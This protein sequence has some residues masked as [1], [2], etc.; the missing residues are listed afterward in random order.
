MYE[1]YLDF[2]KAGYSTIQ[3]DNVQ[4]ILRSLVAPFP[5]Y[6]D[7]CRSLSDYEIG[8][9]YSIVMQEN[10]RAWESTTLFLD[11]F[12]IAWGF[13]RVMSAPNIHDRAFELYQL[14]KL[15]ESIIG[16]ILHRSKNQS[17]SLSSLDAE[18]QL[19]VLWAVRTAGIIHRLSGRRVEAI[20]LLENI[21]P[22]VEQHLYLK[23]AV[24]QIFYNKLLLE[25][26]RCYAEGGH[27]DEAGRLL[28]K[29]LKAA[30][31]SENMANKPRHRTFGVSV[32]VFVIGRALEYRRGEVLQLTKRLHDD[33][34][35]IPDIQEHHTQLQEGSCQPGTPEWGPF[36]SDRIGWD[37]I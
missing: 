16:K 7:K 15:L 28:N 5:N 17:C 37:E 23:Y 33:C 25:L 19:L 32:H 2:S 6:E 1:E 24:I 20:S 13:K 8:N 26:A 11:F 10:L 4:S 30:P 12:T 3:F 9:R 21:I 22:L 34:T 36:L 18:G 35:D 27:H 29:Q 31:N 14:Q